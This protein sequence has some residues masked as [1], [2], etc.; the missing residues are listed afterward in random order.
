M[1]KQ[2]ITTSWSQLATGVAMLAIAVLTAF[3]CLGNKIGFG[4]A[5]AIIFLGGFI[6]IWLI[7]GV[8][9]VVRGLNKM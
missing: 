2:Y 1:S 8:V 3:I 5:L 4:K 9:L 7:V 6:S